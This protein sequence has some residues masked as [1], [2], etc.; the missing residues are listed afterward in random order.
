MTT[1]KYCNFQ[2]VVAKTLTF[3][4]IGVIV[5]TKIVNIK[6]KKEAIRND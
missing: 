6:S 3:T 1:C 4:L 5:G 2:K